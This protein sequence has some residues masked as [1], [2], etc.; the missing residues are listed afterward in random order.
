ME[1]PAHRLNPGE[2]IIGPVGSKM[3]GVY[4]TLS[5]ATK[6]PRYGPGAQVVNPS[7]VRIEIKF[8]YIQVPEGGY[9]ERS[10]DVAKAIE[11]HREVIIHTFLPNWTGVPPAFDIHLQDE[12]DTGGRMTLNATLTIGD[13]AILRR[14]YI[15]EH[16]DRPPRKT[17]HLRE[18][19][20]K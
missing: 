15:G 20:D 7:I 4:L 12:R 6:M 3:S 19:G 9:T 17:S 10:S 2:L 16:H 18:S 1:K 14:T 13:P 11:D 8:Y 5:R